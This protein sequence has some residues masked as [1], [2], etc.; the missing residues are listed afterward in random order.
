[1][2]KDELGAAIGEAKVIVPTNHVI[3]ARTDKKGSYSMELPGEGLYDVF[4]S[5]TG[6]T[7]QCQ[8]VHITNTRWGSFNPTLKV[9]PLT[10]KLHGDSFD[11][12]PV[13]R[14]PP[15]NQKAHH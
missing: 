15:Q 9:D 2:I 14:S 12:K 7:P 8:K 4:V 10:V 5:A 11:T 6:F 1:M 3:S 13:V